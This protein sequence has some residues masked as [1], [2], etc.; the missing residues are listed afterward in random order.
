M[1]LQQY[2]AD[3][4][5]AFA[6]GTQFVSN[7]LSNCNSMCINRKLCTTIQKETNLPRVSVSEYCYRKR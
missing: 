6:Q 3:F 5:S 4:N 1:Y 2:T 7:I